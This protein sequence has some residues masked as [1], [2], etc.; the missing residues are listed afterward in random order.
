MIVGAP[1]TFA[2]GTATST[3]AAYVFQFFTDSS[4]WTQLGST[5]RGAEDIDAVE[6][7]FGAS[8]TMGNLYRVAVGAPQ[9]NQGDGGVYTFELNESSL[10]WTMLPATGLITNN[11]TKEGFGSAVSISVTGD[12]M[13]AGAPNAGGGSGRFYVY[14][15]NEGGSNWIP[16]SNVTGN[17]GEMFGSSVTCLSP[18]GDVLAAGAPGAEGGNGL[19]RVYKKTDGSFQFQ[20]LGQDIVGESGE[21]L[22]G[23]GAIFGSSDGDGITVL[24]GT[25]NGLVRKFVFDDNA[26][27]EPMEPIDT[28]LSGPVTS[29][30]AEADLN[31][32]IVGSSPVNKAVMFRSA[33]PAPGTVA[34]APTASTTAP[35]AGNPSIAPAPTAT[36]TAPSVISPSFVPAPTAQPLPVTPSP[37]SATTTAPTVVAASPTTAP[38]MSWNLTTSFLA[39]SG[40]NLGTSVALV[41]LLM[42]A[43][44][45]TGTGFVNTYQ[46]SSN[47]WVFLSTI[48][49]NQQ[50]SRFGEAI[51]FNPSD[52]GLLIGAPGTLA[53][54]TSTPKGAAYYYAFSGSTWSQLGF[55]VL[56][57]ADVYSANEDFGASVAVSGNDVLAIGAPRSSFDN[58]L[59][60][61]RVYTFVFDSS[62]AS[63]SP[64]STVS[65][66]V[67]EAASDRFG[68][69]VDISS[70]GATLVVGAPF[71]S[72]GSGAVYIYTWSGSE[73]TLATKLSGD[74][75]ESL[76]SSVAILSSTDGSSL[77]A[78]GGAGFGSG[79]GSI[80]IYQLQSGSY[81]PLGSPIV[82]ATGDA[83]GSTNSLAGS[84]TTIVAGT[85]SGSVKTYTYN[86]GSGTWAEDRPAV[87][88]GASVNPALSGTPSLDSFVAGTGGDVQ[89]YS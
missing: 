34:P 19:V 57:D 79:S 66:T 6:E 21:G 25:T 86:S 13:V 41:S 45:T 81:V 30:S 29:L 2:N 54:G 42:A 38:S 51:A 58:V 75:A 9:R 62:S 11:G 15:W 17:T 80:R 78:A 83:L 16:V 31:T 69:A 49:G 32:I 48:S 43:G 60:R 61:G 40:S 56:G 22:G 76:G 24:A 44:A 33:A 37:S 8:V 85:S 46:R 73:W 14:Q 64:R 39:D 26:W 10:A 71:Q 20:Q 3:G 36:T 70:D 82:G 52:G 88:T 23:S 74:S 4:T 63:W 50:S 27:S 67:G 72:S 89:I 18:A 77:I 1:E 87:S 35:A 68:S 84:G 47:S 5:M 53:D 12:R 28:G 65:S 55:P 7:E 59:Q